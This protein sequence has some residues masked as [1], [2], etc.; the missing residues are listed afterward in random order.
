M[1]C[2]WNLIFDILNQAEYYET[3]D[4]IVFSIGVI[5]NGRHYHKEIRDQVE[6]DKVYTNVSFIQNFGLANVRKLGYRTAITIDSIT[7]KGSIYLDNIRILKDIEQGHTTKISIAKELKFKQHK[8]NYYLEELRQKGFVRGDKPYLSIEKL[9]EFEYCDYILTSKGKVAL[10]DH[11]FLL[12]ETI[13]TN[14][15]NNFN[16]PVGSVGNEGTQTNVTGL[17]QGTQIGTQYNSPQEKTLAEAA[18][19]IQ[20]LLQQLE[21]ANPDATVEQQEAY[22][23]AAMPKTLKERLISAL[24]AMSDAAIEEFLKRPGV[25]VVASGVKAWILPGG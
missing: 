21:Q 14:N 22:V 9:G 7:P 4:P 1:K 10:D 24:S 13:M 15:I 17:N 3:N 18:A 20:K 6:F 25:K 23:D 16:A 11:S 5:Y 19:E 12:E 8:V 2:D